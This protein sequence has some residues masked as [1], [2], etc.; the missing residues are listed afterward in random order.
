MQDGTVQ[1]GTNNGNSSFPPPAKRVKFGSVIPPTETTGS[2]NKLLDEL[3]C[4]LSERQWV[5][6]KEDDGPVDYWKINQ[7]RFPTLSKIIP[8]ILTMSASSGD[9]ERMFST[10]TGIL[11]AKRN[12]LKPDFFETLLFIKRNSHLVPLV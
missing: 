5:P 3:N 11:S 6:S 2:G 4:Y 8:P 12:G 9:I 7:D 1:D 10:A